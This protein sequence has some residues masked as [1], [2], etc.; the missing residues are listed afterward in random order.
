QAFGR[1]GFGGQQAGGLATTV[2]GTVTNIDYAQ[3][4][5]QLSTRMGPLTLRAVP[6]QIA[7]LGRGDT[8]TLQF[9]EFEGERWITPYRPGQA[10]QARYAILGGV[11]WALRI[12]SSDARAGGPQGMQ[13][14]SF[15]GAVQGEV[16]AVDYVGGRVMLRDGER[17]FVLRGT[18]GQLADVEIGRY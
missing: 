14:E 13:R 18:P 15:T 12:D 9:S 5:I 7:R 3:G 11:P 17:A 1:R 4:L 2:Q 8:A 10:I 6:G 16:T